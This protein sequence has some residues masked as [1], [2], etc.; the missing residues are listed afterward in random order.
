MN[1][2]VMQQHDKHNT[3][4]NEECYFYSSFPTSSISIW[5]QHQLDY[6]KLNS[7][8]F[9][10][11][12]GSF[13][14]IVQQKLIMLWTMIQRKR[15]K[16][17]WTMEPVQQHLYV[18]SHTTPPDWNFSKTRNCTNGSN[19][20]ISKYCFT[21]KSYTVIFNFSDT[22]LTPT[23][24]LTHMFQ[25]NQTKATTKI[26]WNNQLHH[27]Y[28]K[29]RTNMLVPILSIVLWTM[30]ILIKHSIIY[31]K[32]HA[33]NFITRMSCLPNDSNIWTSMP[34]CIINTFWCMYT[35]SVLLRKNFETPSWNT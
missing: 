20:H 33:L 3:H 25:S 31:W 29:M 18:C 10:S 2:L 6:G 28:Y 35:Q 12:L 27:S 23:N 4:R 21:S 15:L 19:T 9:I 8:I 34:L 32:E 14:I 17:Q 16:E 24:L 13:N 22:S 7:M 26:K 5:K 1:S 30:W 11:I